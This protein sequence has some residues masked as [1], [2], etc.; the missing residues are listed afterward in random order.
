MRPRLIDYFN[1]PITQEEVDFAIPFLDEDIP[2]FLDPFLLWKSPSQQDNSL[3]LSLV[4]AFNRFGKLSITDRNCARQLL[5]E[6]SEC[7][8]VGLGN[9]KTKRGLKISENTADE[10][11]DLFSSIPQI[12]AAGFAHFEEIQLYVSNISKDRISDIS[13]NFLKSFLIDFT[14][15]ECNKYSIPMK[16]FSRQSIYNMRTGRIDLEDVNLP[17]NP[18]DGQPIIFVPKR[19]LRFSPWINYEDYFN[20][21]FIKAGHEDEI[22]KV[23]VL[24]YNRNHYDMI[25]AFISSKER[26]QSDCKN[27]PLFKQIP[28]VSA[29][30]CL[31]SILKLPS[32]KDNNADKQYESNCTRLMAS[33][34]YPHLD[35]AQAQS[36]TDTGTQIRD[37]IFYNNCT[38][39]LLADL[40][41]NYDCKQIVFEMKNVQEISRDHINQLNRYLSEQFGRF[42]IFLTRNAIKQNIF[43]NTIDLWSGQRKCIICL[44]DDDIKMMVDVFES[45]QRDPTEVINKKYVE[46]IR[47][48]PA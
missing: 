41:K 4:N 26:S 10:I 31:N 46:F 43:Q 2:L 21:A 18:E 35:F 36:R 24:N 12:K 34:L 48:C 32:G 47:R 14:Q 13:C 19:W 17:F 27:D 38:Y 16:L 29:K 1:I 15:D 37:L 11:L 8:E 39:P 40:Y 23:K 25:I 6:S 42:G 20:N 5:I 44:T 9:G 7:R 33:L 30:K 45:K 22:E 28:I 3:H